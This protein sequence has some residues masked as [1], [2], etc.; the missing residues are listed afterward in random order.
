MKKTISILLAVLLLAAFFAGCGGPANNAQRPANSNAVSEAPVNDPSEAPVNDPSEA[1]INNVASGSGTAA[2]SYTA[3]MEA[4]NTV[5]TKI[6]DGLSNNPDSTMEALS[7]FG[8]AMID[9][10]ILPAS[11]FGLG[12]QAVEMGLAMIGAEGVKYTENGNN[13]TVT[14]TGDEGE[15]YIYSGTYDPS[16]DVLVCTATANGKESIYSE[17]HKTSYGYIGQYYFVNDDGTATLYQIAT[18]DED[19]TIGI[20]TVSGKPAALTGSEAVDFPKACDI[21]YGIEGKTITGKAS[22]GTDLNFEYTPSASA[23]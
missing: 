22:D 5:I 17:Y 4:K 11:F 23:E 8:V 12:Q 3:Y 13:Y 10:A 20:S 14:Y 15:T 18:K 6:S 9:A 16:A 1:P 21:W 7:F 2:D 19:G